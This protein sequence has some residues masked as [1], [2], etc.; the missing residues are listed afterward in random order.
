MDVRAMF[1]KEYFYAYDLQGRDV[2][3]T[4]ERVTQGKLVGTG[5]KSSKKPVVYF[6]EWGKDRETG[7]HVKGLGLNITNVRIIAAMYGSFKVEDWIGKRITLY[8]TT[9]TFGSQTV[10]CIRIRPMIPAG[11]AAAKGSSGQAAPP[12]EPAREPGADDDPDAADRAAAAPSPEE[13]ERMGG[14]Q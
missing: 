6:R 1:D 3:V 2:T 11:K 7:K 4:I 14:S 5:G 10:D 13:I 8:P 12:Q 9:T